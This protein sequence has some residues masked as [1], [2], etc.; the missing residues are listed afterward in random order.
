MRAINMSSTNIKS[1]VNAPTQFVEAGDNRY[2]YRR[3][4]T[5]SAQPLPFLQHF[6]GTLDNWDFEVT[7]LLAREREVILFDSAGV[8]RS[9]GKVPH[10]VGGMATRASSFLDAL[11]LKT[12]DVLGYSL[13]RMIAQQMAQDRP[14]HL[15][16]DDPRCYRTAGWR[17]YHTS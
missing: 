6:T 15:S 9:S 11:G 16:E 1:N 7:D 10:T 8:G 13:G 17:G 2:A 3:F 14:V 12:C 5:G 4:G